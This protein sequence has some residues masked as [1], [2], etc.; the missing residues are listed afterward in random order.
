MGHKILSASAQRVQD[1]LKNLGFSY[2]VIELAQTT[3]S[4]SDAAKAIG[5][6]VG[7][8][9]KS[10]VF[11][12]KY[13]QR[14]IL[15]IASGSNRVNEKR[16]ADLID[17]PIG[18][19]DADFVRQK[20]GFSIGGVPPVGHLEKLITFIDEDL[21]QYERIWA[22]GGSSNAVFKLTPLDLVKMTGGRVISIK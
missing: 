16:I 15:V 7:Q 2:Q 13:T 17:E 19:A 21:M 14:P 10:L 9:A 6:E 5:C 8:I 22:A 3:R 1:T 4:A 11:K 18:K 12:T 20:T